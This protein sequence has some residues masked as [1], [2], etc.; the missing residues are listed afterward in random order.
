[1]LKYVDFKVLNIILNISNCYNATKRLS[2]IDLLSQG[3]SQW[4]WNKKEVVTHKNFIFR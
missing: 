4:F 2:G 1:M 3:F